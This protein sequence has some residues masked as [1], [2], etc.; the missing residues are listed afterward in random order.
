MDVV[1]VGA[2]LAGLRAARLLA[3]AGQRVVVLEGS[4]RVGGKLRTEEVAGVRVD[5]GAEAMLNRRPE[6]VEL[7]RELGLEVLHP[8]L[9]S[10]RIWT[11]GELRR[12]PRSLMGVPL[13]V[14]DLADSGVV[15]EET[16]ARVRAEPGLGPV[17]LA[18]GEDVSVGDLVAAR[19]G[20]EVVDRLVEPLL[21]GVYAGNARLLSARA[22]V[23][24]LVQYASRGSLLE[25]AAAV[26]TTYDAPVFAGLRGGMGTLAEALLDDLRERGVEVRLGV[27]VAALERTADG[28]RAQLDEGEAVAARQVVLAV[29]APVQASLLAPHAPREAEELAGIEYASVGVITLAV[30]TEQAGALEAVGSSGFLV[31]PVEGRRIKAATFSFAK[32][33]WVKEAGEAHGVRL[34]RTSVGRH[35]EVGALDVEDDELVRATLEELAAATGARLDP[36]ATHVQRWHHGLPQYGLGHLERVARIRARLPEGIAVA[37]AAFDGVGIPAVLASADRAVEH[38]TSR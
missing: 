28:W 22:A 8:A 32:W 16:L 12:L 37:G 11:R 30:P 3:L 17:H 13:D 27:E 6:G 25:Q 35:G 18:E 23:P 36:V 20:D 33:G 31:P 29:P 2:G 7:A 24:Q 9:A 4:D 10:S 34:L 14:D 38:L 15:G 1:V 26:P 5:V 21:G 19:F